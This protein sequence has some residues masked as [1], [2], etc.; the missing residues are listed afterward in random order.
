MPKEKFG[1]QSRRCV[2]M[3]YPMGQ[4]GDVI[5]QDV[6]LPFNLNNTLLTTSSA[7][8]DI[9]SI[10]LVNPVHNVHESRDTLKYEY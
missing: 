2:F 10:P 4:K 7:P 6:C 9:P 5:F 8:K 3:G 1:A